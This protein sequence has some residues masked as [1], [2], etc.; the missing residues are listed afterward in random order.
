MNKNQKTVTHRA[1]P[2]YLVTERADT[3]MLRHNLT[4]KAFQLLNIIWSKI[5]SRQSLDGMRF[6]I[7]PSEAKEYMGTT[8]K[9]FKSVFESAKQELLT[10]PV[11]LD[12]WD[13]S[14]G[15]YRTTETTLIRDLEY[16]K[17]AN[18]NPDIKAGFSLEIP[19]KMHSYLSSL[20]AEEGDLF[21]STTLLI[22]VKLANNGNKYA[23]RFHTYVKRRSIDVI[24]GHRNE[25]T[26][27]I[28]LDDD[29]R[30]EINVPKSYRVTHI[31]RSVINPSIDRINEV[32]D[33]Y[34]DLT[35]T[36]KEGNS[37]TLHFRVL[38][39]PSWKPIKPPKQISSNLPESW[40][41]E[42][43]DLYMELCVQREFSQHLVVKWIDELANQDIKDIIGYAVQLNNSGLLEKSE[44]DFIAGSISKKLK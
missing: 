36:V 40:G 26:L 41:E 8:H 32:S 44:N 10:T 2:D 38:L 34:L 23:G 37:T 9:D 19:P 28:E 5:D 25:K 13:E 4:A 12:F 27:K 24:Q 33:I 43:I 42:E 39:N 16:L 30:S 29:F 35:D 21:I 20:S 18:G 31:M 1:R 17:F 15:R 3:V 11:E 14:I 7:M 6:T 22:K